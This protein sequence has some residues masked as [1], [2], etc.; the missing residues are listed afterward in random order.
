VAGLAGVARREVSAR[1][2]ENRGIGIRRR[3]TLHAT[4]REAAVKVV[5]RGTG[6]I[7]IQ[8]RIIECHDQADRAR[9][10]EPARAH[11]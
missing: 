7:R 11:H 4:V 2:G 3:M 5:R 8:R 10:R 1:L 6:C 9:A